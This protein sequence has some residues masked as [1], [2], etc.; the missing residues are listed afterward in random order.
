MG[1]VKVYVGKVGGKAKYEYAHRLV[2]W[3]VRGPPSHH[4]SKTC[5][6]LCG[7][8]NCLNP[9]HLMWVTQAMNNTMAPWHRRAGMRGRVYWRDGE[10]EGGGS[11]P[12]L[13]VPG[14]E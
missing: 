5:V 3:L 8:A 2:C 10:V 11:R 1:Y 7:V 4:Q 13:M 9:L 14:L 12:R 6:H